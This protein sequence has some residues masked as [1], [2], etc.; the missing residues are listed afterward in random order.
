MGCARSSL[1]PHVASIHIGELT[2]PPDYGS[3]DEPQHVR[4]QPTFRGLA[5][6]H[7]G[8]D[9][10]SLLLYLLLNIPDVNRDLNPIFRWR[11]DVAVNEKSQ[12]SSH[13]AKALFAGPSVDDVQEISSPRNCSR[14]VP[15]DARRTPHLD[16]L[17]GGDQFVRQELRLASRSF[18]KSLRICLSD[19]WAIN[20][21]GPAY[22]KTENPEK[23]LRDFE[24]GW[25]SS[26]HSSRRGE[27]W[28]WNCHAWPAAMRGRSERAFLGSPLFG[29]AM[30]GG[31]EV[32]ERPG[33][34]FKAPP[35]LASP[36]SDRSIETL[37]GRY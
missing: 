35:G 27:I 26:W 22:T 30:P 4:A 14:A 11:V 32:V 8:D 33:G 36:R 23:P 37:L 12:R 6:D 24:R 34:S 1:Q 19:I 16:A 20:N 15:S 3:H 9:G 28:P 25:G 31:T 5:R 17:A 2:R 7:T 29:D 13:L 21:R 10:I 18:F